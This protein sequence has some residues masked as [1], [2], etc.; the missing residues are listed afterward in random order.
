MSYFSRSSSRRKGMWSRGLRRATMFWSKAT[1]RA[2][3]SGPSSD[4]ASRTR[5][6]SGEKMRSLSLE[7][8]QMDLF[9][10]VKIGSRGS[11]SELLLS[12]SELFFL[13]KLLQRTLT[14]LVGQATTEG[15]RSH[16][17][18]PTFAVSVSQIELNTDVYG[19]EMLVT[20]YD[21]FGNATGFAVPLAIARPFASS[22]ESRIRRLD[23]EP[24]KNAS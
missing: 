19:T 23:S 18:S 22:L 6:F 1:Q 8:R 10:L 17:I 5:N 14:K 12:R 24:Q 16:G 11:R 7:R 9:A 2:E 21:K 15:M 3:N 4:L 20:I 13:P